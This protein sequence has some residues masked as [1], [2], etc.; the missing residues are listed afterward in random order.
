M[1]S[2]NENRGVLIN[3]TIN[4]I[5]TALFFYPVV[6]FWFNY[7]SLPILLFM[8]GI[9]L[10]VFFLPLRFYAVSQMSKSRAFYERLL[11]HKIQHFTQQGRYPQ[12]FIKRLSGHDYIAFRRQ[13]MG[14]FQNQIRIYESYH[15]ACFIFFMITSIYALTQQAYA[16]AILIFASNLLYNA[17]PILIQQYNKIRLKNI[18]ERKQSR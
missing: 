2:S 18:R 1:D 7:Y 5:Y 14:Q 4:L 17:I 9:S 3:Q 8:V 10:S 13:N 6:M 11:I 12:R 16:S 15:W